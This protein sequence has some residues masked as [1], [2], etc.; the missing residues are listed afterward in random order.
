MNYGVLFTAWG[1]GGLVLPR[2][3]QTLTAASGGSYTWSFITAGSLLLAGTGL[4][5]LIKPPPPKSATQE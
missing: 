5:F 1:V 3:Q 2:L 4:T